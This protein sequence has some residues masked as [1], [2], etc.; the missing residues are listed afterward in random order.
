MT[1][2]SKGIVL[3]GISGGIVLL[4]ISFI[5]DALVQLIAPYNL[6][7]LG[8]M[9]TMNDPVMILYF[10]YPFIFTFIVAVCWSGIRSCFTG[11]TRD[12]SL[13]FGGFLFLLIIV[14]NTW[15]I[16]TTM[17]YPAGFHISNILTGILGYPIVAYLNV[18]FNNE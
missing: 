18:R 9:R 8:G 1:M 17:T 11:S 13:M 10:L 4:V 3:A 14:P 12:K 5:A 15:V 7:G 2:N 16:F 6:F